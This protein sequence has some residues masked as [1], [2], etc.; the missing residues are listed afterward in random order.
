M[1]AITNAI[2]NSTQLVR[3]NWTDVN[4]LT[5]SPT[6]S[7]SDSVNTPLISSSVSNQHNSIHSTLKSPISMHNHD[8]TA[9]SMTFERTIQTYP[10]TNYTFGTK[11]PLYE[12][13]SS[14]QARFQRMRE[15][16]TT[17]GMRRSVEAVLL[18]H[19][20]NLPHVLLLQLGTTFFKLPGG[21]LNPG[22]DSM[23]GLKRLLNETLGRPDSVQQNNWL[24]ED[25]IGN[26]WRPNFE[27]PR[28]PYVPAHVTKPKEHIRLYLV[29]LGESS[30]FAVPRNYKLVAAPLFELYDNASGYGPIISSL[31]Q[32]LSRF[33]FIYN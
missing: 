12:R 20:H 33:N 25:V 19:E 23:E 30:M 15:E 8:Q 22:E 10:L 2:N 26:W 31:P 21:E 1:S 5:S 9:Q 14:V 29:Q 32:A 7:N 6:N 27:A 17:M 4:S 16:F 24:I 13:D 3:T 11:D 18:V 28:Y